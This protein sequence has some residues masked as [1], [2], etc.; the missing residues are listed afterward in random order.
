MAVQTT[1]QQASRCPLSVQYVLKTEPGRQQSSSLPT[2]LSPL[3]C[4]KESA[5]SG[6]RNAD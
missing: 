4:R 1:T 2:L 3:H 6:A 5:L